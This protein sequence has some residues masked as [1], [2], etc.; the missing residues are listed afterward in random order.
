MRMKITASDVLALRSD[1]RFLS[2]MKEAFLGDKKARDKLAKRVGK[3]LASIIEDEP[4]LRTRILQEVLTHQVVLEGAKRMVGSRKR[5][6]AEIGE[7]TGGRQGASDS[8]APS[9]GRDK[10]GKRA[11]KTIKKAAAK[12]AAA[13]KKGGKRARRKKKNQPGLGHSSPRS[14]A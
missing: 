5:P 13:K 1:E 10:A 9:A 8:K 14:T 7:N 2:S 3:E 6:R 11:Q 4:A 12:K